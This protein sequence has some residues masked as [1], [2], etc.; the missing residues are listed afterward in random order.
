M[1]SKRKI[2]RSKMVEILEGNAGKVLSDTIYDHHA[3]TVER[4]LIFEFEGKIWRAYYYV[5][6]TEYQEAPPWE[7]E[8]EVGVWEV[9]EVTILKKDWEIVYTEDK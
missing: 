6:A 2:P 8:K 1:I 9:K 4:R 3:W 5:G 7:D